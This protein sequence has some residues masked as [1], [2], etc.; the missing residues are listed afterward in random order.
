MQQSSVLEHYIAP[1]TS[2]R[3]PIG[4]CLRQLH[5]AFEH[6]AL[7]CS[8]VSLL[9]I[10]C[11]ARQESLSDL[12]TNSVSAPDQVC[13]MHSIGFLHAYEE[14]P[15]PHSLKTCPRLN[16]GKL[17]FIFTILLWPENSNSFVC[18]PSIALNSPCPSQEAQTSSS[19]DDTLTLPALT[20]N[21]NLIVLKTTATANTHQLFAWTHRISLPP[22][23]QTNAAV[24]I[25][26]DDVLGLDLTVRGLG[27]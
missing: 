12:L 16:S 26:P 21:P 23:G 8:S 14:K 11:F 9:R 24:G 3:R 1:C 10:L 4:R 6:D 27:P 2:W 20:S 13:D 19:P 5:S 22:D 18:L 17:I 7:I 25:R 15:F